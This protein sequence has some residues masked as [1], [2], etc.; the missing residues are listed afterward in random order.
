M[1]ASPRPNS[2]T[3]WPLNPSTGRASSP[4]TLYKP[5]FATEPAKV[6]LVVDVS[7][8]VGPYNVERAAHRVELLR[9]AGVS[10]LSVVAGKVVLPEAASLARQ[11]GVWQLTDGY[12]VTTGL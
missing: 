1:R 2:S 12:V 5:K 4:Q 6:Y 11:L 3:P 7:W 10:A 8:G 9:R